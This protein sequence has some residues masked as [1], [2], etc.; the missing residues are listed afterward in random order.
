MGLFDRVMGRCPSCGEPMEFQSKAGDC[1]LAEFDI[2][3]VPAEVAKD[4]HGKGWQCNRCGKVVYLVLD[5]EVRN[6]RM[7]TTHEEPK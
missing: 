1:I 4:M 2:V 5:E 3:S 6:V 7:R